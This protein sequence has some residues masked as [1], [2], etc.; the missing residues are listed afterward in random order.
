MDRLPYPREGGI[1]VFIFHFKMSMHGGCSHNYLENESQAVLGDFNT[2]LMLDN[3]K[4]ISGKFIRRV[5]YC[6]NYIF[7]YVDKDTLSMLDSQQSPIMIYLGIKK[8]FLLNA[9]YNRQCIMY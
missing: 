2:S 5:M 4:Y 6:L 8:S 7:S 3:G 9:M 1:Y